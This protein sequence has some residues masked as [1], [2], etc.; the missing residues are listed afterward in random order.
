MRSLFLCCGKW[1]SLLVANIR[2]MR[3]KSLTMHYIFS[4]VI[5]RTAFLPMPH[6]LCTLYALQPVRGTATMQ[7]SLFSLVRRHI[8][9]SKTASFAKQNMPYRKP[10]YYSMLHSSTNIK[11]EK[12]TLGSRTCGSQVCEPTLFSLSLQTDKLRP[13]IWKQA[14][15]A[16]V[17]IIFAH[18][19]LAT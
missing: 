10:L 1:M 16:L 14:F 4:T 15:I 5:N 17:Y 6:Y 8:L 12:A 7:K 19:I 3:D 9:P 2:K 11:Y 13:A 18:D